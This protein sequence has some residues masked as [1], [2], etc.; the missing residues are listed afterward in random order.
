M[1]DN[2]PYEPDMSVQ[3][4]LDLGL[5][6]VIDTGQIG[7]GTYKMCGV[8]SHD[9]KCTRSVGHIGV[10]AYVARWEDNPVARVRHLR[11]ALTEAHTSR[12]QEQIRDAL[13]YYE[14]REQQY[15]DAKTLKDAQERVEQERRR[16][17][18]AKARARIE[19]ERQRLKDQRRLAIEMNKKMAQSFEDIERNF[20]ALGKTMK[21]IEQSR[22][23]PPKKPPPWTVAPRAPKR[24]QI[25]PKGQ[26]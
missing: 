16:L 25:N 17:E 4:A 3:E 14:E 10:H 8:L 22:I 19:A 15:L 26:R 18:A 20:E 21:Q 6:A 7:R 5:I 2:E 13:V 24:K 9:G 11:I 1:L 23:S 12:V